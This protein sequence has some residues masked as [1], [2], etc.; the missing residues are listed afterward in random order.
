MISHSNR[1]TQIEGESAEE[2]TCSQELGKVQNEEFIICASDI[3]RVIT[4]RS[5]RL[6]GHAEC[7]GKCYI[8]IKC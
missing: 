1:K 6:A 3:V 7:T 2:D 5:M 8:N 4:S